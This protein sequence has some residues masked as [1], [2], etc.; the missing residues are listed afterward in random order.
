[1]VFA[2]HARGGVGMQHLQYEMEMEKIMILLCHLCVKT[3]LG[4][5]LTILL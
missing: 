2:S 3:Q 5:D 1:M 4:L